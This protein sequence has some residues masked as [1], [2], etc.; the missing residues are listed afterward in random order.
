MPCRARG[1]LDTGHE[2]PDPRRRA[3]SP[4][5]KANSSMK[6]P[7]YVPVLQAVSGRDSRRGRGTPQVNV[8]A[9]PPV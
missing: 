7:V 5:T 2:R 4:F 8:P 1:F 9:P 6:F 3:R